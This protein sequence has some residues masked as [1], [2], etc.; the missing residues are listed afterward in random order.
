MQIE[1]RIVEAL[2]LIGMPS[3][4]TL[5][6][7]D[8]DGV[9][10]P[11]PYLL[12]QVIRTYSDNM[13][14]ISTSHKEGNQKEIIL[15]VKDYKISLTFHADTKD[16]THDWVDYFHSGIHSDLVDWAFTQQGLGLVSSDDIIYLSQPVDGVNYKRAVMDIEVRTEVMNEYQV[17]RL[18]RFEAVGTLVD[19]SIGEF[20]E[21]VIDV[22]NSN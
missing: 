4:I 16:G 19:A 17:N 6:L 2:K 12:V 3:N 7:A 14:S 18:D 11:A 13:P 21:V 1:S 5:V 15:Q 10:P 22:D 8:R 20:G 9:E